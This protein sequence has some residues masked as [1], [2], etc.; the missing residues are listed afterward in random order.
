MLKACGFDE[1]EGFLTFKD[2]SKLEYFP[3]VL[4]IFE[5]ELLN[6]SWGSL[7]VLKW[8]NDGLVNIKYWVN[9]FLLLNYWLSRSQIKLCFYK[10]LK[11]TIS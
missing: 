11:Q 1:E 10:F 3:K 7:I 2:Q 9:I 4:E 6:L 8:I 5:R